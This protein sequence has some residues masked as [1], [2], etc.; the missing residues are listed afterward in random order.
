MEFDSG[1]ARRFQR[2]GGAHSRALQPAFAGVDSTGQLASAPSAPVSPL[3]FNGLERTMG[4]G[5]PP[6]LSASLVTVLQ[7]GAAKSLGGL[8]FDMGADD[9]D[10]ADGRSPAC[11]GVLVMWI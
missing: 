5:P 1:S 6:R 8:H 2:V 3:D 7:S 11:S 10:D 9:A 4:A